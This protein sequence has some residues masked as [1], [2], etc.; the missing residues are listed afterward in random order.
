MADILTLQGKPYV[1]PAV[2]PKGVLDVFDEVSHAVE[3]G[4][5]E[6]VIVIINGSRGVRM[7]MSGSGYDETL[8]MLAVAR[9]DIEIEQAIVQA[10]IRK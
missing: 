3:A 9:Y 4:E 8:N 2:I 5:V 1:P 7:C 10:G 6:Q